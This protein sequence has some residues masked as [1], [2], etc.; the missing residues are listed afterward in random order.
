MFTAVE[1]PEVF[2]VNQTKTSKALHIF[3]QLKFISTLVR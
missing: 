3:V 1:S 2:S